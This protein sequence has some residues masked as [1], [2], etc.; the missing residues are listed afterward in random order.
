[1]NS[2]NNRHWSAYSQ[3]RTPCSWLKAW[4]SV[5]DSA[6]RLIGRVC[7]DYTDPVTRYV[8]ILRPFFRPNRRR[9]ATRCFPARYFNS[10]H[11][12]FKSGSTA[13]SVRLPRNYPW[14]L[15]PCSSELTHCYFYLWGSWKCKVYIKHPC[16]LEE[17]TN[18][19]RC[20]ISV[21]SGD[22]FQRVNNSV[23]CRY[24]ESIRSGRQRFSICCGTSELLLHFLKIILVAIAYRRDWPHL[25][26]PSPTASTAKPRQGVLL[27]PLSKPLFSDKR[28][29][30]SL[31]NRLLF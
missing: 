18:N 12:T 9:K 5:C 25:K 23:F 11:A 15:T 31:Y 1:V 6:R 22:E 10:S 3:T 8:N 30:S 21:I 29:W 20:E 13:R 2:Q 19:I 14:S 4:C 24:T 16:T 17:P 26:L 28:K 27:W 7:H